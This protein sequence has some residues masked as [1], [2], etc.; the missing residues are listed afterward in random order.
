MY[1]P[2]ATHD[3]LSFVG[4]FVVETHELRALLLVVVFLVLVLAVLE[5]A[6]VIVGACDA[7]V[8]ELVEAKFVSPFVVPEL[9]TVELLVG[10]RERPIVEESAVVDGKTTEVDAVAFSGIE[11]V[12]RGRN[13][14]TAKSRTSASAIPATIMV[15]SARR[16]SDEL[17]EAWSLVISWH[18][19]RMRSGSPA[20]R[21]QQGAW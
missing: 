21:I 15:E 1:P 10:E 17:R 19:E 7:L 11:L 16:P 4:W 18:R 8:L 2:D 12:E 13:A 14:P 20:F 5:F 3:P 6:V 9:D